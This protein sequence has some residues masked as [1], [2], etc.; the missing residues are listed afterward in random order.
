MK[1]KELYLK[2]F[3]R[4][5]D[6]R[7]L[8]EDGLNIIYGPNEA[9]KSTLHK[10]IEGMLF[11]FVKPGVKRRVL[12]DDHKKYQ[13]WDGQYYEGYMVYEIDGRRYRV[14]RNFARGREEV[15]IYDDVS[16]ED[17]TRAFKYD[18]VTR[19]YLFCQQHLGINQTIF[20]NTISIGQLA[21]RSDDKQM[22]REVGSRLS[23]INTSWDTEVS[24]AKAEKHLED[25]LKEIGTEKAHTK[26]YGMLAKKREQLEEEL[27]NSRKRIESIRSLQQRLVQVEEELQELQRDRK[28]IEERI[29]AVREGLFLRRWE[30]IKGLKEREE[31]VKERLQQ[32]SRYRDFP[33][34]YYEELVVLEQ[35]IESDRQEIEQ[36]QERILEVSGELREKEEQLTG[37]ACAGI[38]EREG[39]EVGRLYAGYKALQKR[40]EDLKEELEKLENELALLRDNTLPNEAQLNHA[41]ELL[42]RMNSLEREKNDPLNFQLKTRLEQL[43]GDTVRAKWKI[44]VSC[45]CVLVSIPVA[46]YLHPLLFGITAVSLIFCLL[47]LKSFNRYREKERETGKVL[48]RLEKDVLER[49]EE[50]RRCRQE[51]ESIFELWQVDN[52]YQMRTKALECQRIEEKISGLEDKLEEKREELSRVNYELIGN[53]ERLK[54]L[55][56]E[57]GIYTGDSIEDSHIYRFASRVTENRKA[58]ELLTGKKKQMENLMDTLKKRERLLEERKKRLRQILAE[59]GVESMEEYRNRME[60]FNRFQELSRELGEIQR[61]L[62]SKLEG[63]DYYEMEATAREA[64][65]TMEVPEEDMTKENLSALEYQLEL[66]K[67]KEA[68]KLAAIEKIRGSMEVH[69]KD[70]VSP[71]ELEEELERVK[72]R[73]ETLERERQAAGIALELIREASAQVHR[74]FAPVLNRKVGEIVS[75]ITASRY[76]ELRVTRDLEILAVSPETGRQVSAD[77]LS[78]GTIDQLYFACRMAMADLLIG[79]SNLPLILDD[80]FVQ[81]DLYRLKNIM[82]YLVQISEERQII[83]FTCHHRD[84]EIAE[85]LGGRFNYIQ[86]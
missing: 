60:G 48:S 21:I 85:E 35:K 59:A 74:E 50:Y 26:E 33:V 54:C 49:E 25:V 15:R 11:G 46:V 69:Q 45:I 68:E 47:G 62:E 29:R 28:Q 19:E 7:V 43:K 17:I 53:K 3:G 82:A 39:M 79:R 61:L 24:V 8:L 77:Q 34:N 80:S 55:L 12:L 44:I 10:F 4:F 5:K 23:N 41:E 83:I 67:Q 40:A 6:K 65:H 22:V 56:E 78:G 76:R 66:L 27:N 38:S 31:H 2:G 1:I 73:L 13:P 81:Y 71:A 9:G 42:D 32:Y 37:T 16:G 51:L 84:R 30:D 75:R 64:V 18:K 72:E 70:L 58:M 36:L 20:K 14:E 86:L 57:A 52:I 63:G